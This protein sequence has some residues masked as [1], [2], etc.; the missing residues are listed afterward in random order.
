MQTFVDRFKANAK[1]TTLAQSRMKAIAKI[2]I[3]MT[4]EVLQDPDVVF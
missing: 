2:Q 1:L 3:G 4:A